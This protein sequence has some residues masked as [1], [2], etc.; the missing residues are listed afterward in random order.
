VK[1]RVQ[2]VELANTENV[3]S[4]YEFNTADHHSLLVAPF[5]DPELPYL[6][7]PAGWSIVSLRF[8]S[9]ENSLIVYVGKGKLYE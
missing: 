4:A 6:I 7:V 9:N 8:F 1:I 5:S 3:L 2:I